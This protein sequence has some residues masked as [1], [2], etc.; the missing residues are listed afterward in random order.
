MNEA[1]IRFLTEP[2]IRYRCRK[3]LFGKCVLQKLVR[4]K[5][6]M[7]GSQSH[8]TYEWRDVK[9]SEIGSDP[10]FPASLKPE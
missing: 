10:N 4:T 2:S 1:L 3:S 5:F 6:V 7:D 8:S 9:F